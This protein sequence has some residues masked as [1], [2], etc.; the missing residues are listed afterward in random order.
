MPGALMSG[1]A[2]RQHLKITGKEI[3]FMFR[4][5]LY[6][7]C[8]LRTLSAAN[9]SEPFRKEIANTMD[10]YFDLL[11]IAHQLSVNIALREIRMCIRVDTTSV[12]LQTIITTVRL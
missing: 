9:L 4:S 3:L 6:L 7:L 2:Y 8:S 5:I 1:V 11:E 12:E 10:I